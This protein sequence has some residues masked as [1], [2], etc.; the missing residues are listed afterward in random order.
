MRVARTYLRRAPVCEHLHA[1]PEPSW[2]KNS[3]LVYS[4]TAELEK[5]QAGGSND[6]TRLRVK[7]FRLICNP[8]F[9][10]SLHESHRRL[11]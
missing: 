11:S 5:V 10:Q 3:P 1:Y 7:P 4:E 6:Y 9:R 2:D 8:A